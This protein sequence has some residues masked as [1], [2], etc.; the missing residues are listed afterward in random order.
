ARRFRAKIGDPMEP[1]SAESA[2]EAPAAIPH[3]RGGFFP[4]DERQALRL[5]RFLLAAGTSLLVIG[6]LFASEELGIVPLDTAIRGSTGIVALIVL[7]YAILRSGLNLRLRDPSLTF[8]QAGS[9]ILML[10]Y[11]MYYAPQSRGS[12]SILYLVAMM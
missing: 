10:A 11:V 7:F 9:A 3:R 1:L 5:R 6:V 8:E 4:S 2:T 12:L